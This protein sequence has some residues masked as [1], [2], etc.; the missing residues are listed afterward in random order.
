MKTTVLRQEGGHVGDRKIHSTSSKGVPRGGF[1]QT[2]N[3]FNFEFHPQNLILGIGPCKVKEKK[4][5][6]LREYGKNLHNF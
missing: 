5:R 4:S 1:L 6:V 2:R 3:V